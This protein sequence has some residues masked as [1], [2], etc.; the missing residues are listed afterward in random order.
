MLT[1]KVLLTTTIKAT[2]AL[3]TAHRF[4]APDG[5]YAGAGE[6]ALGLLECAVAS[7]EYAPVNSHGILLAE[8][9]GVIAVGDALVSDASGRAVKATEFAVTSVT[10]AGAVAVLANAATPTITNT[11]AGSS[12]PQVILGYAL[13]AAGGAGE[14][15][16]MKM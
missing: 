16:R 5:G 7:G 6:F 10:G 9:G 14:L 1:E 13:D 3:A 4:V 12:L 11:Y 15:V 8:S 2:A